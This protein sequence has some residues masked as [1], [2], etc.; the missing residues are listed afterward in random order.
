MTTSSLA[1]LIANLSDEKLNKMLSALSESECEA[2]FYDWEF[3]ARPSQLPPK[4]DWFFWLVL[5]GRGYGKTRMAAEWIRSQ[6]EGISPLTA[7]KNAPERIALVADTILD[8]RATM[9]EGESGII[10]CFPP[11]F[12]PSFEV[13]SRK[14][15]WPNGIQAFLYSSEAP[16]QLRG[17]QHHIAWGDEIAKWGHGEE[18]WS[19]LLFGLR[20]G[21]APK[22]MVTTT[23]RNIP[24]MR[25]LLEEKNIYITRGSTYDNQANLPAQFM[26][27][28]I[29]K[30]KGTR[31]GRQ[32]ING[33]LLS[34]VQGA[35][36]NR[37]MLERAYLKADIKDIS[38]QR[39]I[40]A[41]DPPVTSGA[42]A[43]ACGIIV[44]G[45]DAAGL[46]YVI[47]DWS[48]RGL[49]PYGWAAKA[50]KAYR[51]YDADRL[52]AEVNNGGELVESLLRQIDP[53]V[54]YK[55]VRASKG[56]YRRAEPIA[57]LY[58][59]RRIKHL[60]DFSEL[61]DEMCNLTLAGLTAGKSPDRTD[62][63]VWAFTELMLGRR[64]VPTI[65]NI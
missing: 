37:N 60:G 17:P 4:V 9:I 8:G 42:K 47:A 16:D 34:D 6:V 20:L 13:T 15:I 32:E 3:W 10:S 31:L 29:G 33:E 25:K 57:A 11:D 36:W 41:I 55:A 56:K 58:E 2:L 27:Q 26:D 12:R 61:E 30:Y 39:I 18:V 52:T 48:E 45:I 49:S 51:K 19:N 1:H 7:P 64:G 53:E 59:Q 40:V 23:P 35:L 5:A 14:L 62:A 63:L 44:A 46:G 22:V 24:L 65:R 28:V 54:S 50:L 43:D 38:W 21:T